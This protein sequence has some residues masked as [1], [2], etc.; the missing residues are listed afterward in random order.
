SGEIQPRNIIEFL[1]GE[2]GASNQRSRPFIMAHGIES[3]LHGWK[4]MSANDNADIRERREA[5][6]QWPTGPFRQK[7]TS[8]LR[9][10]GGWLSFEN[11][12]ISLRSPSGP[13]GP[14]STRMR[15]RRYERAWRYRT[16][17]TYQA[18]AHASGWPL[19]AS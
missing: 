19:C 3:D 8:R 17:C 13:A 16:G 10:S 18:E 4:F 12:E 6:Q 15:G 1:Q 14:C 5:K 2:N 11:R 7:Q 9:I